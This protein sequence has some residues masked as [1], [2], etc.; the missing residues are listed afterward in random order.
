M[1]TS[2]TRLFAAMVTSPLLLASCGGGGSGPTAPEPLALT[3][4]TASIMVDGQPVQ[5]GGSFAAGAGSST[6]FEARL[7]DQHGQPAGRF[8][9]RLRHE[10]PGPMV[11]SGVFI[12]YDDRT[13]GD[14]IFGDGVYTFEDTAGIAGFHRADAPPGRYHYD[15]YGIHRDGRETNHILV[16]VDVTD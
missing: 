16:T 1:P 6:R 12:L 2:P 9:V 3:L 11:G 4:T 5:P 14:S 15:F 13:H 8:D 7:A 10:R